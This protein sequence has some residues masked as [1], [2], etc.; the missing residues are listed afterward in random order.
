MNAAGIYCGI[1][2]GSDGTPHHEMIRDGEAISVDFSAG[3]PLPDSPQRWCTGYY[4]FHNDLSGVH[5]LCP[6][7]SEVTSGH[8]C[9]DCQY[10]E[11]FVALHRA[12]TMNDVPRQLREYVA[13]EHMLYLAAF[14]ADIVKIGTAAISR[15]PARWYEQGAVAAREL[16]TVRDGIAVRRLESS[17]SRAYGL[18]QALRGA[19]KAKLLA[20]PPTLAELADGLQ[21]VVEQ[22]SAAGES[23][24]PRPVWEG[25]LAAVTGRTATIGS[26]SVAPTGSTEWDLTGDPDAVGQCLVW[27]GPTGGFV[28]DVKPLVGQPVTF[29]RA[30]TGGTPQQIALL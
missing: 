26:L 14:G 6:K 9:R 19:T 20:E 4:D 30:G 8:Q 23:F 28:M 18:A 15:H 24:Q 10:R 11:G 17:L 2:W 22:M 29:T 21:R 1:L 7:G 13:Q 12:R 3:I 25:S 5:V 27:D 16:A